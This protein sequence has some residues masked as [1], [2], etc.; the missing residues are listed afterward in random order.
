MPPQSPTSHPITASP[1]QSPTPSIS[2][3]R[4]GPNAPPVPQGPAQSQAPTS[5]IWTVEDLREISALT[6]R[7]PAALLRETDRRGLSPIAFAAFQGA[8]TSDRLLPLL[9]LLEPQ[10]KETSQL[11]QVIQLLETIAESQVRIERRVVEIESRLAGRA[12]A[13]PPP[14]KSAAVASRN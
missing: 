14:S 9:D 8:L 1:T 12:S 3:A 2:P 13:S 5:R 11:E 7:D 4:S 10:E 6:V